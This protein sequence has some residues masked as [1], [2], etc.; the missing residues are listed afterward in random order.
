VHDHIEPLLGEDP[1]DRDL[2]AQLCPV[3]RHLR[4]D[5][6]TVPEDEVIKHYGLLPGEGQLA[7]V[8]AADVPAPPTTKT[9]TEAFSCMDHRA[10]VQTIMRQVGLPTDRDRAEKHQI[11]AVGSGITT[12]RR[13]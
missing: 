10:F 7:G 8:V 9:F 11:R 13:P 12:W 5:G 6:G 2:V 3:E 1:A 4:R